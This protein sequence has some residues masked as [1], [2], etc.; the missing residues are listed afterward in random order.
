MGKKKKKFLLEEIWNV[1][2]INVLVIRA[3]L[4]SRAVIVWPYRSVYKPKMDGSE[5]KYG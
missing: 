5:L 4:I 1:L 3:V 2:W